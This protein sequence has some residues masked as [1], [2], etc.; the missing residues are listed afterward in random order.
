ME[1][2]ETYRQTHLD[3]S[4]EYEDNVLKVYHFHLSEEALAD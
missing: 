1:L 2:C 4:I 3:S